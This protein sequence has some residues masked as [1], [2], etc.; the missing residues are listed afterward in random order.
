[1]YTDA[2]NSNGT[3]FM[4]RTTLMLS[5][6]WTTCLLIKMM[7]LKRKM[8]D[9]SANVE[10]K[11]TMLNRWFRQPMN[12]INYYRVFSISFNAWWINWNFIVLDTDQLFCV[13]WN[14][15]LR[16]LFSVLKF[17]AVAYRYCIYFFFHL[18]SHI[19]FENGRI[20]FIFGKRKHIFLG[21]LFKTDCKILSKFTNIFVMESQGIREGF[22]VYIMHC[23]SH[24]TYIRF[25]IQ[26]KVNEKC[27]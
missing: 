19:L 13:G 15:A 21:F 20:F 23:K 3:A 1:M 5:T 26:Q 10:N 24:T 9:A 16:L 4:K 25:W 11:T 27:A 17:I 8:L 22:F 18:K 6:K 12:M 2:L 7:L 14:I